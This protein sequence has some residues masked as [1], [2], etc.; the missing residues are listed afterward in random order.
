MKAPR[1]MVK[2]RPEHA[3]YV[4]ERM[5]PDEIA[6]YQRMYNQKAYD[7]NALLQL[8]KDF[9][10]PAFTVLDENGLPAACG[11]YFYVS[12]GVWRSWMMGTVRGWGKRWRSLTK[13]ARWLIDGMFTTVGAQR[14]ETTVLASRTKAMEWYERGLGLTR[15][16]EENGIVL[17]V[18]TA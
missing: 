12:P 7:P 15:E 5:R 2:F 10:G 18:R 1:S 13:A 16:S 6:Q 11:G 8:L 9:E 4:A 14:L 17:F 3:R